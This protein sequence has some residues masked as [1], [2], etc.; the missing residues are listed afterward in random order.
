ML[1]HILTALLVLPT[2]LLGCPTDE[3]FQG[4]SR[5]WNVPTAG[6]SFS[7]ILWPSRTITYCFQDQAAYDSLATNLLN[8]WEQ[9]ITAGVDRTKFTFQ[10]SSTPLCPDP[11]E[12]VLQVILNDGQGSLTSVG[13]S[14]RNQ[15][16]LD[17]NGN[18]ASGNVIT[19]YAHEIGHAWGL[20]HEQQRKDLWIPEYGGNAATN[21]FVFN[22]Q[23][24]F[25]YSRLAAIL[26]SY[27]MR[28]VCK[29]QTF[30]TSRGFSASD[31]LP[32]ANSAYGGSYDPKSI[33]LYGSV[34][35][36]VSLS[37]GGRAVVLAQNNAAQTTW[38][39]NM[40]PSVADV[41]HLKAMYK[42]SIK[43]K[44]SMLFSSSSAQQALFYQTASSSFQCSL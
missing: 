4:L 33:M 31:F 22:C 14:T 19:N 15:M 30:A 43:K 5:R 24:L 36:G 27:E 1:V 3:D 21:Y 20:L 11:S 18:A 9:W 26:P 39:Y 28:E 35:G 8:A 44:L 25:D 6:G 7:N 37:G 16:K 10:L 42:V 41:N 32:V 29:S 17:S 13:K 38:G 23:N 12:D 40:A 34:A 2:L